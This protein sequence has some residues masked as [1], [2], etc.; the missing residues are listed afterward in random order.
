MYF[1]VNGIP[2]FSKGSN[3]IP[4]DAFESRVTDKQIQ[5]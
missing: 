2:I 4:F 3:L 1:E 5:E